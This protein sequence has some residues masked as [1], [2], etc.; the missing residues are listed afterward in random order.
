[1]SFRFGRIMYL[2]KRNQ[3]HETMERGFEDL[4]ED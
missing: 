3:S 2:R 1:M 4:L